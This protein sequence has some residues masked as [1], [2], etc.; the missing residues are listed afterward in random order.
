MGSGSSTSEPGEPAAI[1]ATPVM[2]VIH[3][4]YFIPYQDAW[5][6][7]DSPFK[8][9]EKSRRVGFTYATSYRAFKKCLVRRRFT[10]W[11]SSRD[12]LTAKEFVTDYLARWCALGNVVAR[13]LAGDNVQVF[14]ADDLKA[15]V[16]EFP[17][18]G[19]RVVSLSSTPEVFAGKGGDILLDELDL[20]K[21]PGRVYDMA[22]P[23]TTWGGQ[24]EAI[25]AYAVDG[26]PASVFAKLCADARG[27][28]PMHASLHRVTLDDAIAAGFVECVN[29][30]TGQNWTREAFRA[31][32]RAG[33]RTESAFQSQ[34]MCNPQDEG[35]ALLGYD[36]IASCEVDYKT[37][38]ATIAASLKAARYFLGIDV[39]RRKDLTCMWL[40]ALIGDILWTAQVK[41][42]SKALFRHQYAAAVALMDGY[43][44]RRC[45]VD[46]TGIGAQL[47]EDLQIK[48]G[49]RVEPIQM[50]HGAQMDIGIGLL[51]AFQDRTVRIPSDQTIREGLHKVRKEVTAANHVRLVAEHDEAGHA[52][53]FWGL[54]L[55]KHA[56]KATGV[57]IPPTT[58]KR[59]RRAAIMAG[60]RAKRN[61]GDLAA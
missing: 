40:A 3:E 54:A 20:H 24:L 13:G 14:G 50:T 12:L 29:R 25:S 28:N 60:R 7:D 15:F 10:Q 1:S 51:P 21:D 45:C 43:K 38:E 33:C 30:V 39:A 8:L 59:G 2:P 23:C 16:V 17:M 37:L 41:T 26:S 18:T 42:M 5:I 47:G 44:V 27:T 55:C 32:I 52:D 61:W 49:H 36:L 53:E 48:Y 31:H 6:D 56:A 34:Y 58:F 4:S 19:S 22:R 57:S 9:A 11:V 35:G 46:A